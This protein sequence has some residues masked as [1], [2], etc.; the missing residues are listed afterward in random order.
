MAV[1]SAS[2][3]VVRDRACDMWR[4]GGSDGTTRIKGRRKGDGRRKG[5]ERRKGNE[6]GGEERR[7]ERIKI[8][9]KIKKNKVR[10]PSLLQSEQ[11]DVDAQSGGVVFNIPFA[12][13][14]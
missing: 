14:R 13:Q 11:D 5:E 4:R 9:I 7:G 10:R 2:D 12:L 6:T 8:K 1:H 3:L